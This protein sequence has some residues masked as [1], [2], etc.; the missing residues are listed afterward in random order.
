MGYSRE[1]AVYY[2]LKYGLN[3]N[4][5]YAYF[6][7]HSGGGGD[8][9]NFVSQCLHAGGIQ[10]DFGPRWSWWYRRVS[11][12]HP[13]TD[14]WSL[15]WAVANSLYRCLK[16]RHKLN[17]QGLRGLEVNDTGLLEIGDVIQYENFDG[18]IYHSA[19][20]TGFEYL[21]G[22][23]QPLISQHSFDAVNIP[24]MKSSSKAAHFIR[25]A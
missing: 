3:P 22:R 1:R 7:S 4:P 13:Q 15:S 16:S 18:M 23:R 5:D 11:A 9:T 2:A 20:I 12:Y 8:C 25:I 21:G 10:M 14:R 24:Y 6:A 19:I 17:M